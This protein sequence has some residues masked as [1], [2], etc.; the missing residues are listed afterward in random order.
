MYINTKR[1][2]NIS[3]SYKAI[4]ESLKEEQIN[5]N[6]SIN[7]LKQGWQGEKASRYI[8][9]IEDEYL[10]ELKEAIILLNKYYTYLSKIPNVYEKLDESYL[11]KKINISG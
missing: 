8:N 4:L 9:A 6:K 1:I 2:T 7:E 3:T 11:N 10:V 5:I